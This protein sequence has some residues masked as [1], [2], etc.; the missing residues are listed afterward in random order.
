M[1]AGDEPELEVIQGALDGTLKSVF[2]K[3]YTTTEQP[4][5]LR[6]A[7]KM[8]ETFPTLR[9]WYTSTIR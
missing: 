8:A 5:L 4:E 2:S 1:I 3:D 7:A 6:T 9:F